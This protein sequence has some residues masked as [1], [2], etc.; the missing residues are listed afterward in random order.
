MYHR[1]SSNDHLSI[2]KTELVAV[3]KESKA[4]GQTY[5]LHASQALFGDDQD[6]EE[7]SE[8]FRNQGK[9]IITAIGNTVKML[10]IG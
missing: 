8:D 1:G 2:L 10:K 4:G 3:G 7:P 9:S 5:F 6:E